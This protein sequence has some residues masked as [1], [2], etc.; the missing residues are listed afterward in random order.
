[1]SFRIQDAERN[2][3][4]FFDVMDLPIPSPNQKMFLPLTFWQFLHP[5]Q[6]RIASLRQRK[7]TFFWLSDSIHFSSIHLLHSLE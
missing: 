6:A 1:M 3:M 5:I 2:V 7:Q 4:T